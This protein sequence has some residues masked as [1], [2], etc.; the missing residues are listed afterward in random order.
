METFSSVKLLQCQC[1]D[2]A[3]LEMKELKLVVVLMNRCVVTSTTWCIWI[4]PGK[5]NFEDKVD[6]KAFVNHLS[7]RI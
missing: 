7:T 6:L 2:S 3:G 4:R 5:N 1:R